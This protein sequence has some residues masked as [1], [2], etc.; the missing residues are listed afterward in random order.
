VSAPSSAIGEPGLSTWAALSEREQEL[1]D[2][3]DVRAVS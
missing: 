1:L 3:I 2:G